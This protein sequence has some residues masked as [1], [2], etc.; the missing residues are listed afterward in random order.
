MRYK[1]IKIVAIGLTAALILPLGS[2]LWAQGDLPLGSEPQIQRSLGVNLRPMA[3]AERF[4]PGATAEA[5]IHDAT[6]ELKIW[7]G[8]SS[9]ADE[10]YTQIILA[11]L[12]RK[13]GSV[14]KCRGNLRAFEEGR[15]RD[16]NAVRAG[17]TLLNNVS[18][19]LQMSI[20]QAQSLRDLLGHRLGAGS[21]IDA[22]KTG[23]CGSVNLVIAYQ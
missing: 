17:E 1:F 13:I 10:D 7:Q 6:G 19:E 21:V 8:M 23:D 11:Y 15:K 4:G 22:L 20:R 12:R 5:A 16:E 14:L 3:Y 9:N 18:N 2:G